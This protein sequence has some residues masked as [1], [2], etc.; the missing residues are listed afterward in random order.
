MEN[1]MQAPPTFGFKSVS[2]RLGVWNYYFVAK[3][4]LF[5]MGVIGLHLIENLVLVVILAG[6]LAAPRWRRFRPWLGVPAA[7]ALLYYDS[8]LPGF[9]R[10]VSQAG[11]VSSFSA[12]YLAELAGRFVNWTVLA[13]LA[14]AL[15]V[16]IA[17]ARFVRI[18]VL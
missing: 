13:A 11:I 3:L 17:I 7:I 14:V 16:C 6:P 12:A 15:A 8:W 1:P 9:A 18:D 5:A 4:V 2:D 10:V